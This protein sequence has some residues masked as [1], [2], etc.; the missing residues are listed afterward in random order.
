[1]WEPTGPAWQYELLDKLPR[2]IDL[3]QLERSLRM[4]PTERME[5]VRRLAEFAEEV[6]QGRDRLQKA[7]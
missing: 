3:A 2:G 7:P 1:M 5:V 6:R 4:T